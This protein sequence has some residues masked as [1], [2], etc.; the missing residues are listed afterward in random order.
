MIHQPGTVMKCQNKSSLQQTLK[1]ICLTIP[2]PDI[3]QSDEKS[4]KGIDYV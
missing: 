4:L 2:N 3:R 1:L